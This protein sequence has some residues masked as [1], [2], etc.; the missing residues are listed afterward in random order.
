MLL[1]LGLAVS[2][3]TSALASS[4]SSTSCSPA[5]S[6][7][8]YCRVSE[9]SCSACPANAVC[10]GGAYL[11]VP[12]RGYWVDRSELK[13]ARHVYECASESKCSH[14]EDIGD[15]RK[16]S[17][18]ERACWSIDEREN[19]TLQDSELL[20]NGNS[21]GLF[22]SQCQ[23]NHIKSAVHKCEHCSSVMLRLIAMG[24]IAFICMAPILL[25]FNAVVKAAKPFVDI[26]DTSSL[27]I[28]FSTL[29][30]T[31]SLPWVLDITFPEPFASLLRVYEF[32][33]L[34]FV[35]ILS[36]ECWSP[37]LA[38]HGSQALLSGLIPVVIGTFIWARYYWCR[39]GISPVAAERKSSSR[40]F[41]SP[42]EKMHEGR[43][44]RRSSFGITPSS[45]GR[46]MSMRS[47][48][49]ALP[50][51]E[52]L[53]LKS[54]DSEHVTVRR[55]STV[56]RQRYEKKKVTIQINA[57]YKG[58][59]ADDELS[60]LYRSHMTMFLWICFL[61]LPAV[62]VLQFQSFA[63]GILEH[64][65]TEYLVFEPSSP[66]HGQSHL[67]SIFSPVLFIML[68]LF[69]PFHWYR[70][71]HKVE[72]LLNPRIA[73]DKDGAAMKAR[74]KDVRL[75]HHRFLW[76][77]YSGPFWYFDVVD[78]SRRTLLIGILPLVGGRGLPRAAAGLLLSFVS[79]V[80]YRETFP[81]RRHENNRLVMASQYQILAAYA[82]ATAVETSSGCEEIFDGTVLGVYLLLVSLV[83]VATVCWVCV[84]ANRRKTGRNENV[85]LGDEDMKIVKHVMSD[86]SFRRTNNVLKELLIDP[87]YITKGKKIGSG[88]FGDV[89]KGEYM[90]QTVAIKTT[91]KVSKETIKS[92]RIEIILTAAIRHPNV[93]NIVGACWTKELTC[94]V[95]EWAS[96][97]TME[98]LLESD[99]HGAPF[100]TWQHPLLKVATDMVRGLAHMHSRR[101]YDEVNRKMQETVIHRDLKPENV[102]VDDNWVAKLSDFGLSTAFDP[103]GKMK[104]VGTPLYAAPEVM[105]GEEYDQMSDS[106]SLGVCLFAMACD[107][108]FVLYAGAEYEAM[109]EPLKDWNDLIKALNNGFRPRVQKHVP[110]SI[111]HMIEVCM[112]QEPQDR[113]N[114]REVLEFLVS[115]VAK[116]VAT[117]D[118]PRSSDE[119]Y[120]LRRKH[121]QLDPLAAAMEK[122]QVQEERELS[123]RADVESPVV[124][125]SLDSEDSNA[126]LS[127]ADWVYKLNN[128]V[129]GND[130]PKLKDLV[131]SKSAP[132]PPAQLVNL[133]D[134]DNRTPAHISAAEGLLDVL[135]FLLEECGADPNPVDRWGGTPLDDA[136]RTEQIEVVEYLKTKGGVA[137]AANDVTSS[138]EWAMKLCDAAYTSNV[139]RLRELVEKGARVNIGDYDKRT[140]LHLAASEAKLEV[141]K[142][143]ILEAGADPNPLDRWGF[144]PLDDAM[145]GKHDDVVDFLDQHGGKSSTS[146]LQL[147][148]HKKQKQQT[149]QTKTIE[150]GGPPPLMRGKTD[151]N[152]LRPRAQTTGSGFGGSLGRN[153]MLQLKAAAA[154]PS[155]LRRISS[156]AVPELQDFERRK[157]SEAVPTL[158]PIPASPAV[159]ATD[160]Q[161][162]TSTGD[163]GSS[164][165]PL[166]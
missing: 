21:Q 116:E 141:V 40:A 121:R 115:D 62:A 104:A 142:Y 163:V 53:G 125:E 25:A 57:K 60:Q 73:A 87:D 32:T 164:G 99:S 70:E 112:S 72:G 93:I 153:T 113:P 10:E 94:M 117:Q 156:G 132:L 106:Y 162:N 81:Y 118:F 19:C 86:Q 150:G 119:Y 133:G 77:G 80:L 140:P 102:L 43:T 107:Q 123:G 56:Q 154:A 91:K 145:R 158:Q 105:K 111:S 161:L 30:I 131:R 58:G 5:C 143:L 98:D 78:I 152:L 8:S 109:R 42:D 4:A 146:P 52:A 41:L 54:P 51:A 33:M 69:I 127:E 151:T 67:T 44:R 74:D 97:G 3:H 134:Y 23:S 138:H 31:A 149:L 130:I 120:R 103:S 17:D 61:W 47:A 159:V 16:L 100:L 28:I 122:A 36:V 22:C 27:K 166:K 55:V 7:G 155:D 2:Q 84:E 157:S 50:G 12:I 64:D 89:F 126:D 35:H 165:G 76:Q 82:G 11:P 46:K 68:C 124:T 24:V 160:R 26:L 101:F 1:L 135:K 83:F 48:F 148:F 63:C 15:F 65:G 79:L 38:K 137:G 9:N 88:A 90:G 139:D 59:K 37:S 14:I 129:A 29:Q 96:R 20:C 136:S 34:N 110:E 147:A 75:A 128:A 85:V 92:F 144:T 71:L 49:V 95:L 114:M 66:C 6:E 18:A 108:T 45:I 39:R 13:W